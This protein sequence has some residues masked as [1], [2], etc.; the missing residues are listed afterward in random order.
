MAH[1][2]LVGVSED[3]FLDALTADDPP[4]MLVFQAEQIEELFLSL[5]STPV[6]LGLAAYFFS[7]SVLVKLEPNNVHSLL[8]EDVPVIIQ[9]VSVLVINNHLS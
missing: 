6:V 8:K 4:F 2:N 9:K 5:P 3:N 7:L 1:A